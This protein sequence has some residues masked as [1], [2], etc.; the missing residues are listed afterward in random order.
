K[1]FFFF[2]YEGLRLSQPL[3]QI[4]DVPSLE[5]RANASPSTKPI[6]DAFPLPNGPSTGVDIAQLAASVPN[7]AQVDAASLRIDHSLT[8]LINLFGRFNHSP[9]TL[10]EPFGWPGSNPT[11]MEQNIDTSTFGMTAIL[12]PAVTNDFHFN[13]GR[14][15]ARSFGTL[16]NYG[17]AV[18]PP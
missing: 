4:T 13:Y 14:A 10:F 2:S 7:H 11:T 15:H 17:G 1:T 3:F 12:P 16:T 6:I 18:P 9:P 8:S 5:A